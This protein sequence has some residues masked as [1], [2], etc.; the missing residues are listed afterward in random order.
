MSFSFFSFCG[1]KN[2]CKNN[3]LKHE[4][5]CKKATGASE[6][7]HNITGIAH[8]LL[9]LQEMPSTEA[10]GGGEISTIQSEEA[11]D[12]LSV[13]EMPSAED[14]GGGELNL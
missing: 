1:R 6:N 14:G 8:S 10:G 5:R 9:V 13:Q 12:P 11:Q 3:N 4:R 7:E 2:K